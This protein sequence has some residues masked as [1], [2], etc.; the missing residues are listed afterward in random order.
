MIRKELIFDKS[1][2]NDFFV[3]MDDSDPIHSDFLS[4]LKEVR[5]F[6]LVINVNDFVELEELHEH[7]PLFEI[8]V[9]TKVPEIKFN[10]DLIED[11]DDDK[12]EFKMYFIERAKKDCEQLSLDLGH[13]VICTENLNEKWSIYNPKR[14]DKKRK[15]TKSRNIPANFRFDSWDVLNEYNHPVNS[16]LVFDRYILVDNDQQKIE[17]NLIPLIKKLS[18]NKKSPKALE[19]TI[20][21]SLFK[22]N[23]HK[24][25]LSLEQD[26]KKTLKRDFKLNL[27]FHSKQGYPRNFEG[28]KARRIFTNY[29]V[30]KSEDSFNY[31]KKNGR[32][33]NNTEIEISFIFDK[34]EWI[35]AKKDLADISAYIKNIVRLTDSKATLLT[36]YHPDAECRM[37]S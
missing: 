4:F 2:L 36:Y 14:E 25:Y 8:L 37:L 33:N 22:Y 13:E 32:I 21:T 11:N 26:L 30:I 18:G 27:I 9:D 20:V 1:F 16:I 12:T 6:K 31:F 35:L 34:T 5:D 15:V 10:A 23:I 17:N 24:S 29:F 19:I 3:L 28:L 7:N